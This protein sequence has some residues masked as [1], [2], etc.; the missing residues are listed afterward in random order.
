MLA[1]LTAYPLLS[2]VVEL[3]GGIEDGNVPGATLMLAAGFHCVAG[4]DDE[5]FRY[6]AR[7]NDGG[8]PARPWRKPD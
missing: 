1:S 2:R 3:F 7:R 5:G 8:P 4:K 6:Y